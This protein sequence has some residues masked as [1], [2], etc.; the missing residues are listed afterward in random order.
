MQST[1]SDLNPDQKRA[2]EIIDGPVL[3]VAG[4]GTGKT[5]TITA[6]ILYLL[7]NG[8]LGENI[9]ALTFTN[10]AAREMS[11]RILSQI[12]VYNSRP[13]IRTFHSLALYILRAEHQILGMK[14]YFP[15]YDAGQSRATLRN[16]LKNLGYDASEWEPRRIASFISRR[17]SEGIGHTDISP[18]DAS[19]HFTKHA[20]LIWAEYERIKSID[21]A[22]DFDDLLVLVD[23]LFQ[24]PDI[25]GKYQNQ[26]RYIHIDEYQDTNALQYRIARALAGKAQNIFAVGDGDQ[27][28]YSWRGADM[29]NILSF[30]KDF[31]GAKII[32]LQE[33]YRSKQNILRAADSVISKNTERIDKGFK[34]STD[35][36]EK[37]FVYS[38]SDPVDEAN[39]MMERAANLMRDGVPGREIA[40][41]YRTNAQSRILEEVALRTG[42]PYLLLGT[43][44][45]DRQE[46]RDLMSYYR[47][48]LNPD[49][50]ADLA[51]AIKTPRRGI[52]PAAL[53]KICAG[54]GDQLSPKQKIAYQGFLDILQNVRTKLPDMSPADAI[55]ILAKDSG[56]FELY[57]SGSDEDRER[58]QNIGELIN[59]AKK[60]D[61]I[62]SPSAA[63]QTF[64]DEVQLL[65][66]QDSDDNKVDAVRMMTIHAAKGLEFDVVFVVGM[67]Q[68]LF[69]GETDKTE[70]K[71]EQEEER[72]LCYVAF[73]RAR[74]RLFL[75]W[76]IV[77]SVFGESRVNEPSTF[78]FDIPQELIE[79]SDPDFGDDLWDGEKTVYL[80]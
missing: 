74:D 54:I 7:R 73:T 1:I 9:L 75:S 42:I 4:A 53:A 48:L 65:S 35:N 59:V 18:T 31:S 69:P 15:V 77:R 67:E 25:V 47:L 61:N 52:G 44:F 68:G 30:E 19:G 13:M 17:K 14:K 8:V 21:G 2:S 41:L 76:S 33:N 27:N 45:F 3:V 70:T 22:C 6:R 72:R 24:N 12:P 57:N 11:E 29:R 16:A 78:L 37:I 34:S 64:L 66:D 63:H 60:Y 51:R 80:S 55:Q 79:S 50:T 71:Y 32:L 40:V 5:R 10:K 56:I 49:S 23:R 46:V 58:L 28:I 20:I 43:R 39:F 62:T 36:G 38:A 26:F